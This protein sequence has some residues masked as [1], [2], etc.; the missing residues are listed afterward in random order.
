MKNFNNF[1]LSKKQLVTVSAGTA[2]QTQETTPSNVLKT[3]HDTAK[4]TIQNAR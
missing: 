1:E 4:N 3:K 2:P